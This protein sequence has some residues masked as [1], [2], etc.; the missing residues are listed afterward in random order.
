MNLRKFNFAMLDEIVI[1]SINFATSLVLARMMPAHQF[2]LCIFA[3]T[4]LVLCT[5][6]LNSAVLS[7]LAVL[8]APLR[9]K[10]WQR[11]LS[12]CVFFFFLISGTL[13]L[14]FISLS[15]LLCET[16]YAENG[17][18]LRYVGLIVFVYL[19]QEFVRRLLIIRM[20]TR[21]AL[22]VD[23]IT[24][25][26][27]LTL[28]IVVVMCTAAT[29]KDVVLIFG[30][31]SLTGIT[32]AVALNRRYF[33]LSKFRTDVDA[34][35]GIWSYGKWT[36]ADWLPFVLSGQFYIYVVTIILGNAANGILGACR[37]LVAPLRVMLGGF[38]NIALPY[39]TKVLN[40]QGNRA[41]SRALRRVFSVFLALV[42]SYVVVISLFSSRLLLVVFGKYQEHGLLVGLFGFAMIVIYFTSPLE[43]YLKILLQPR[44]VFLSR[45]L[46]AITNIAACFV[47]ITL[48]GLIGAAYSYILSQITM[49]TFLCYFV[50]R[51]RKKCESESKRVDLNAHVRKYAFQEKTSHHPHIN[52]WRSNGCG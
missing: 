28:V 15:V 3:F 10:E 50:L 16:R 32:A 39:Y 27:R 2:G 26:T 52:L 47:L 31:S 23:S 6:L 38:T 25:A 17:E 51:L 45:L 46:T 22:A 37:N 35:S 9:E 24:Y 44:L 29:S 34:I 48:Y 42:F 18:L 7:P 40:Q 19:G 1:S 4:T 8:A 13:A 11:Y 20:K 41:L 30:I 43:L 21:E 33:S 5:G 36:L 14:V 49:F 12:S